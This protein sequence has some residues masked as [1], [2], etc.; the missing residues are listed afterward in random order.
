MDFSNFS[1]RDGILLVVIAIA[2]YL[3]VSLLRLLQIRWR[4]KRVAVRPAVAATREPALRFD[5]AAADDALAPPLSATAS[6]AGSFG[7]RLLLTQLEG[8]VGQLRQE[9]AELRAALDEIKTARRVSPQYA[10]AMLM[11]QRGIEA[12]DIADRCAISIGEAELVAAL[13]RNRQE[14]ETHD[15]SYDARH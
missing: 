2:G 7:E 8:E 6:L 4:S 13:S 9:V 15:E 1:S 10:E 12:Q 3:L 14:Y 11:A 5:P